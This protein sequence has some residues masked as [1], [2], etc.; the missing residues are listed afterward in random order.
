MNQ[1][2]PELI[3]PLLQDYLF[4]V[5]QHNPD[6]M[7]AF[8]IEGSIALGGFNEHLSDID[9]VAILN[10][11]ATPTEIQGLCHTHKVIEESHPRWKMSGSYLQSANLERFDSEVEPNLYYHDGV[12]QFHG[13]FELNS[14][15]GWILKNHGIAIIGPEPQ[16]LPFT[17]D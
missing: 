8:Y 17:V 9:L 1:R 4:L 7:K 6:L 11:G 15:E 5:S 12:L 10:H 14:V 3:R 13:H 16:D 2:V